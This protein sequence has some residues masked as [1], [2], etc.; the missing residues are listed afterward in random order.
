MIVYDGAT[1]TNLQL[2]RLTADDFGGAAFEGCNEVLVETRPDVVA[3]LHRSFF[4]VGCD[5]VETDSFGDLPWVLADHG[6]SERGLAERARQLATKSALIARGVADDAAALTRETKWV[7]GSLGPGTK[8]ASLGQISFAEQRDGYQVAAEGL[9][10]GGVDLFIVETVQDLR[11]AEAAIAGCRRAMEAAGKPVPIQVQVTVDATGRMLMGTDLATA[12][13]TLVALGADVVGVNCATGP[14]GLYEHIGRLSRL[15]SVPIA[16]M[17]S[18]GLPIPGLTSAGLPSVVG[19]DLR[20]EVTPDQL[21]EH[22]RRFVTERGVSIV[23]G[24]CGT[25]PAHLKAVVE[26]LR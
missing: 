13:T 21:A 5:A 1:G 11:G 16:V 23:G 6:L 14:A 4:D 19:G 9:L 18:A 22:L 2:L 25:T 12:L 20:Y 24:C 17:P 10:A 3:D 26:A 8:I 15:S 7:A